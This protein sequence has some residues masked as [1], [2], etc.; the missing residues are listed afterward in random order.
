MAG[1]ARTWTVRRAAS[2]LPVV[3]ALV[4]ALCS[5]EALLVLTNPEYYSFDSPQ[6]LLLVGA[7]AA[8]LLLSLAALAGLH[9]RLGPLYGTLGGVG[10]LLASLGTAA[11][12]A[13]HVLALPFFDFVNTGGLVYVL[14]ALQEGYLLPG[15]A[16][17]ALGVALMSAGYLLLAAAVLRVPALPRWCGPLL[18]FGM[19]GL[20]LTGFW[21]WVLF[22]AAWAAVG[23]ALR[24]EDPA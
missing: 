4:A 10:W 8:A 16:A 14:V 15:P 17:Y 12:G 2:S 20:W 23:Y 6:D 9:S 21:G 24:A 5:L 19:A 1:P 22:G 11:A 18:A 7:E 13:G 3:A